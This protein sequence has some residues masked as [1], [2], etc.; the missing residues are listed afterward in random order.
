MRL[1][2]SHMFVRN[3]AVLTKGSQL[4][5]FQGEGQPHNPDV[6]QSKYSIEAEPQGSHEV[7]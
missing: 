7:E 5:G 2:V 1:T 4:Q 3:S 6:V